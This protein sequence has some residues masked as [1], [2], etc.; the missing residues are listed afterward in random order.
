[1]KIR[2]S[3][4]DIMIVMI[5]SLFAFYSCDN[6]NPVEPPHTEEIDTVSKYEWTYDVTGGMLMGFYVADT[7]NIFFAGI[8]D[9]VYY[10]GIQFTALNM[11]DPDFVS[12]CIAGYDKNNVYF[13]GYLN[14]TLGVNIPVLKKWE[15]GTIKT[16]II[17]ND[18]CSKINNIVI[19]GYDKLLLSSSKNYAYSFDNGSVTTHE[20]DSGTIDGTF[21]KNPQEEIFLFKL[22]YK[23]GKCYYFNYK[24][25]NDDFFKILVD[26]SNNFK[27]KRFFPCGLDLL[28]T[29]AEYV[30]IF[31]GINW[32]I[33]FKISETIYNNVPPT[34]IGGNSRND[35]IYQSNLANT[36]LIYRNSKWSWEK[37]ILY[38]MPPFFLL[39]PPRIYKDR[40]YYVKVNI[41]YTG[42]ALYKGK[43]KTTFSKN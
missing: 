4:Y 32:N 17:S 10:D 34:G 28:M 37:A 9:P 13:G 7:T 22:K 2:N 43:L 42:S 3:L 41:P 16:Y 8:P 40:L 21:F 12:D 25:K 30:Y 26:S 15:N 31:N 24:F 14:P 18:S 20:L 27:F 1:M 38:G 6:N 35:F 33:L 5:I 36:M 39:T 19:Q 29:D 11:Q 23:D